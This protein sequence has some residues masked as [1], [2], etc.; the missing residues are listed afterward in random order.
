MVKQQ[1]DTL[2]VLGADGDLARRLLLPG[3]ATLLASDWAPHRSPQLIGAG[4]SELDDAGWQGRMAEASATASVRGRRVTETARRSRFRSAD[5][6]SVEDLRGLL[7]E[8]D[9]IPA[10]YF[11]LPPA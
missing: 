10:I 4:L 5:V 3:L 7:E 8:C 6:T 2:L 11:A 9:G 1:I